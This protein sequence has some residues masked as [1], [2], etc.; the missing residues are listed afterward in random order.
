MGYIIV[1]IILTGI[2]FYALGFTTNI[3]K[4][5]RPVYQRNKK[6]FLSFFA[7]LIILF[8]MFTTVQG[9]EVGIVYDPIN[10]G[11]QD[12]S[13][14]EGL[15]F[16]A[17][18]VRV[19]NISTKLRE[20]SFILTSQTGVIYSENDL[21]ELE[22][23]G[24]GQWVTYQVTLQYRVETINAHKFYRNFG[25][26]LNN[27]STVEARVKKDLQTNSA[28]FD[29]Y[30]IL[31]GGLVDVREG[32]EADLQVSLA[33]LGITVES[34][35]IADVDAGSTIESA[36]EE[37]AVAAKEI[38][39]A[40]QQQ[41]KA[42]VEAET[43]II[44]ANNEAEVQII[45]AEAEAEAQALLN[46]V[47]INAINTMYAQQFLTTQEKL[48]FEAE[49]ALGNTVAGYLTI[50][51]ISEIIL[52]QLYYDTWDGELPDVVAGDQGLSLIIPDYSN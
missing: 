17:P 24:G 22:E 11:I 39:I 36:V 23:V 16:K 4:N 21:G 42:K 50:Q 5:K 32:T 28:K 51:E 38:E 29:V 44:K 48:D 1:S 37:E 45:K 40:E 47:T 31:K 18:W 8:G 41:E 13:L 19:Y 15:H 26:T 9:N 12:I 43:A 49:V 6:Q 7:L 52:T 34:F 10:G 27:I 33:D 35:T 3:T 25:A 14:G 46:S 2:L 30:T 20:E